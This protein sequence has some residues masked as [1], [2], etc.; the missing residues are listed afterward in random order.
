[1]QGRQVGLEIELRVERV[2]PVD[3]GRG[4]GLVTGASRRRR[5]GLCPALNGSLVRILAPVARP[6][7]RHSYG[8]KDVPN[9]EV[10]L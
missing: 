2:D 10:R 9:P 4:R 6:D 3:L 5:R 1:M 7:N 8:G